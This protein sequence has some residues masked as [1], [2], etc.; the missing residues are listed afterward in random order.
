V[1]DPWIVGST[2]WRSWWN[3]PPVSPELLASIKPDYVYLTHIHWD[4]FHGP[5]LR[6]FDRATPVLVPKGHLLYV[7]GTEDS[8]TG[9]KTVPVDAP[10]YDQVWSGIQAADNPPPAKP[11][12]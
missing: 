8:S 4:H 6:R 12:K 11:T 2:Y 7:V 1:C 10:W 9:A 3:Y 5:S